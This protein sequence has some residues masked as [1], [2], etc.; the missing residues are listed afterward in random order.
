MLDQITSARSHDDWTRMR[1]LTLNQNMIEQYNVQHSRLLAA[2]RAREPE[3][4]ANIMKEHLE[5]ARLSMT[6]AA[7]T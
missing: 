2:L 1:H 6:R 5:T 4:A 7:E 3:R